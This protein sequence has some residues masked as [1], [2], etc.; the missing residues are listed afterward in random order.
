MKLADVLFP[1]KTGNI[2]MAKMSMGQMKMERFSMDERSLLMSLIDKYIHI[3]DVKK[4]DAASNAAK[5]KSWFEIERQFN[6][7]GFVIKR[8]WRQ[9]RKAWE[10][11]KCK[12]KREL[13]HN[14]HER[15]RIG[16]GPC[17]STSA[18]IFLEAE[19]T[20]PCQMKREEVTGRTEGHGLMVND[21]RELAY[22]VL[23]EE[24]ER[25]IMAEPQ[26]PSTCLLTPGDGSSSCDSETTQPQSISCHASVGGELE[27]RVESVKSMKDAVNCSGDDD[28]SWIKRRT[29]ELE[30]RLKE[31]E[32][33]KA[34]KLKELE[35]TMAENSLAHQ[36]KL[37]ALELRERRR[38][39]HHQEEMRQRERLSYS[40]SNI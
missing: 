34:E 10:N 24:N 12:R 15:T 28:V 14:I 29:A 35:V 25:L 19:V 40:S 32:V 8:N 18:D 37:M 21:P 11:I 13:A 20:Q 31:I 22:E 1:R 3:L 9:L 5:V 26:R 23:R 4:T 27:L 30:L 36:R 33:S 6:D 16:G 7:H 38:Q 39:H 2:S 17:T